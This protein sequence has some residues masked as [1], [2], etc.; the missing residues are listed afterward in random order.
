MSKPAKQIEEN[1]TKAIRLVQEQ[2]DYI[3]VIGIFLIFDQLFFMSRHDGVTFCGMDLTDIWTWG[4]WVHH[5]NTPRRTSSPKTS[6]ATDGRPYKAKLSVD[7]S[8]AVPLGPFSFSNGACCGDIVGGPNLPRLFCCLLR[9]HSA[10][11]LLKT[12]LLL[13]MVKSQANLSVFIVK[14]LLY[15]GWIS[16]PVGVEVIWSSWFWS[17]HHNFASSWL[18]LFQPPIS[19]SVLF[20]PPIH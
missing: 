13:K 1:W 10:F 6:S 2:L 19:G 16:S 7:H 20:G 17:N 5:L 9:P 14:H 8:T 11:S 4:K 3:W 15:I 12:H 18:W